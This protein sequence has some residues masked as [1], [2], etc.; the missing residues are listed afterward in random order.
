MKHLLLFCGLSLY[1]LNGVSA[2]TY[3]KN[4]YRV[5]VKGTRLIVKYRGQARRL[6]TAG[7]I[8]AAKVTGTEILFADQKD[9]FT[10][11]VIDVVGQ[12][13]EKQNDRQCGAGT[14]ANLLWLKLD[15]KLLLAGVD[16]ARYE[17]CWSAIEMGDG[18]RIAGRKLQIE[19]ENFR[20][21]VRVKLTYNADE[22]E[23]GFQIEQT[24]LKEN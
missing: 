17:S 11:L 15:E 18:V 20:E 13:R 9:G 24:G 5:R 22:P 4:G 14:E 6:G 19:F 23:K 12:S 2:Q 3:E 21:N 16:S 7:R 8:D 10:Y 1:A